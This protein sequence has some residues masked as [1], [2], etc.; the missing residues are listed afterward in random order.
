M[1]ESKIKYITLPNFITSLNIL[2]GTLAVF[3]AVTSEKFLIPAAYLIGFAAIFDFLDGFTARLTKAYSEIGKQLDSLAD[4]ISFGLAPSAIVFQMLK[5]ALD[6]K[7]FSLNLPTLDLLIL[8][9]AA[10]IA[11]FS[12]W[13]LA[14]FNIDTRQSESFIGMPTPAVAIFIASL[15]IVKETDPGNLYLISKVLDINLPFSVILGWI[16]LQV[17]VLESV[18]F[19]LPLIAV[20]S[21][22]LVSEFPMFSLKFK[23]FSFT[24]NKTRYIFLILS[25]ILIVLLQFMALPFIIIMFVLMS[26]IK[27]LIDLR[28]M[29]KLDEEIEDGVDEMDD[30]KR[31]LKSEFKLF[32]DN[33]KLN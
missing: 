30:I 13:R 31:E 16:G 3:L 27:N 33:I 18:K 10:L 9:S 19:F 8:S 11:I 15:P 7:S 6:L 21:F 22:L 17:F 14:K 23:N 4:L 25:V 1:P 29:T 32:E 28:K 26:G 5:K 24:D 2:S 12:A 20:F